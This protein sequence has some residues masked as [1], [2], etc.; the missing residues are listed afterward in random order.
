MDARAGLVVSGLS[1]LPVFQG[2]IPV[3]SRVSGP[4]LFA[5]TGCLLFK[6]FFPTPPLKLSVFIG[7]LCV[8]FASL[9]AVH[10]ASCCHGALSPSDLSSVKA[11]LCFVHHDC[12]NRTRQMSLS[13]LV[14]NPR[15]TPITGENKIPLIL[16][17][18]VTKLSILSAT[19]PL[20]LLFLVQSLVGHIH[21]TVKKSN[22]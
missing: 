7:W 1:L 21:S 19:C 3:C 4:M 20:G 2:D 12:A 6:A 18:I 9:P 16:L 10:L 13:T 11:V 15:G 17:R 14:Y 5:H 22:M 8:D